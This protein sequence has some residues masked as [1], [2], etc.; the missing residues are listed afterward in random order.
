MSPAKRAGPF[1]WD[2]SRAGPAGRGARL[3]TNFLLQNDFSLYGSRASPVS[4]DLTSAKRGARFAGLKLLHVNTLARQTGL[5]NVITMV[6]NAFFER[7]CVKMASVEVTQSDS[8]NR[9]AKPFRWTSEM[10]ELL[11]N[12][13]E[14]YKCLCE[15][16]GKDFDADR[17]KQ[18]EWIRGKN[19]FVVLTF[20]EF[21]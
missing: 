18:Y 20:V 3:H 5:E 19:C 6:T 17:T 8:G 9:K 11:I 14:T 1:C 16:E 2:K 10:I 13:L 21:H 7:Y 15:Y 12:S 4:R